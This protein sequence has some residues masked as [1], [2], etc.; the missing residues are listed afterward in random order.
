MMSFLYLAGFGDLKLI[1]DDD[2]P[3]LLEE[4]LESQ[5]TCIG[6]I[7]VS[8]DDPWIRQVWQYLQGKN[9]EAY[10]HLPLL[11]CPRDDVLQLRPLRGNYVCEKVDGFPPA[12]PALSA[13]LGLLGVHVVAGLPDWVVRHSE[14]LHTR[15]QPAS[16]LGVL[17]S[18]TRL[19]GEEAAAVDAAVSRFNTESKAD[20]RFALVEILSAGLKSGGGGE[21]KEWDAAS[22]V[23]RRLELFPVWPDCFGKDPDHT[24]GFQFNPRVFTSVQ[25]NCRLTPDVSSHALLPPHVACSPKLLYCDSKTHREL[26]SSLG[27]NETTLIEVEEKILDRLSYGVSATSGHEEYNTDVQT[28]MTYFLESPAFKEEHLKQVAKRIR[29]VPTCLSGELRRAEELYNPEDNLLQDLFAGEDRFPRETFYRS[30]TSIPPGL[31][32]LGLRDATTVT[33]QDLIDA[34]IESDKYCSSRKPEHSS[35][36][37]RKAKALWELLTEHSGGSFPQAVFEQLANLQCLPCVTRETAPPDYP[38]AVPVCPEEYGNLGIARPAVMCKHSDLWVVGSVK[39]VAPSTV[40]EC[41]ITSLFYQPTSDDVIRH[42]EIVTSRLT[43]EKSRHF[44]S[45]LHLIYRSLKGRYDKGDESVK[46]QVK[47]TNCILT[48]RDGHVRRPCEF[49]VQDEDSDDLDLSPYRFP[50]PTTL[51]DEGFSEFFVACGCSPRQ[52]SDTLRNVLREIRTKHTQSRHG[53]RDCKRDFSLVQRILKAIVNKEDFEKKEVLLPVYSSEKDA[54]QFAWAKDCTV[55]P[56]PTVID[57]LSQE[58]AITFVHPDLDRDVAL[59]LGALDLRSRTLTGVDDLEVDGSAFGQYELL[60][61]RLRHLLQDGYT[62]GFFV[63]LRW[64]FFLLFLS[65]AVFSSSFFTVQCNLSVCLS[66]C[67]SVCLARCQ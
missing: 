31:K 65:L 35:L 22:D 4:S 17:N 57:V 6:D 27:A 11:P 24:D 7:R 54:L 56:D 55:A 53:E 59:K 37:K 60:T 25:R 5:Y 40:R 48:E 2:M 43:K 47:N 63:C 29:F 36:A 50:L 42:L 3:D 66:L 41:S 45:M 14:V 1:S 9:L 52:D 10:D 8:R 44:A 61:T 67:L 30:G 23:L 62:D 38:A 34:A 51:V 15:V 12:P 26:A 64:V 49:W 46:E 16:C 58:E 39:P 33:A 32:A 19:A 20:E 18:L 28:F 13:A 21:E